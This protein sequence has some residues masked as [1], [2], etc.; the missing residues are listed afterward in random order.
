MEASATNIQTAQQTRLHLPTSR[1]EILWLHFCVLTFDHEPK[2]VKLWL[3]RDEDTDHSVSPTPKPIMPTISV[4]GN[5]DD[6][7]ELEDV[8]VAEQAPF[9]PV[10]PSAIPAPYEVSY[11]FILIFE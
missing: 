10:D 8:P 1:F 6:E 2:T 4:E 9:V 11:M 7:R 5:D 3:E